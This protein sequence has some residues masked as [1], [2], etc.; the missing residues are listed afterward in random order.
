[1]VKEEEV[2]PDTLKIQKLVGFGDKLELGFIDKY[3]SEP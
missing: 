1:M 2:S 3:S